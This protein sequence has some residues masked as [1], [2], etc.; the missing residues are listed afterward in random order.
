MAKETIDVKGIKE[1]LSG[2]EIFLFGGKKVILVTDTEA[3]K[4][5][6]TVAYKKV[7]SEGSVGR[8]ALS[9]T[10]TQP[11]ELVPIK[12]KVVQSVSI[13]EAA[14]NRAMKVASNGKGK[15][16]K[17]AKASGP[18]EK[19]F[20]LLRKEKKVV[21]AKVL[22]ATKTGKKV[23]FKLDGEKE[24]RALKDD[25]LFDDRDEAREALKELK[26]T[27]KKGKKAAGKKTA[28]E[29]GK[30]AADEKAAKSAKK[31]AKA[32]CYLLLKKEKKVVTGRIVKEL[33]S[34]KIKV[35]YKDPEDEE[36]VSKSFKGDFIFE[37]RAE[38]K[39]AL[40]TLKGD[41]K[42]AS[43]KKSESKKASG[44]K[45]SSKKA[46][47]KKAEKKAAA[48]V[49]LTCGSCKWRNPKKNDCPDYDDVY[50][51]SDICEKYKAKK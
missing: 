33:S 49:E 23:E 24:A 17:S 25:F 32:K 6:V 19:V 14:L 27:G 51:D 35:Q 15:G 13:S 37:D 39:A 21:K 18:V 9:V 36:K 26:G 38:A 44:K 29:T 45:T 50:E 3:K 8:K 28:K 42:K 46:A 12:G 7:T 48:T 11:G 5:G 22:K 40:K 20:A 34:G 30:K 31:T 2:N 4:S 16:K 41:G 10:I 47:S 43:S 1:T